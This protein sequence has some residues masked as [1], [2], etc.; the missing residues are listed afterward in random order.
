MNS[1]NSVMRAEQLQFI[2][3]I[4]FALI[5]LWHADIWLKYEDVRKKGAALAVNFFFILSGFLYSYISCKKAISPEVKDIKVFVTKKISKFYPLY[6]LTTLFAAIFSDL[7]W[8]L[9]N[10]NIEELV[11]SLCQLLQN[12]LLIQSWFPSDKGYFSYNSV[13][14]FL[15]TIMF[16]YIITIPVF[17]LLKKMNPKPNC[18]VICMA[19]LFVGILGYNYLMR[20]YNPEFWTYISPIG[21]AGVYC[22]GMLLGYMYADISKVSE[23]EEESGAV[24]TLI[25]ILTFIIWLGSIFTEPLYPWCSRIIWWIIPNMLLIYVF[26]NGKGLISELFRNKIFVTLGNITFEMYLIHQLVI[27]VY[28]KFPFGVKTGDCRDLISVFACMTITVVS[29]MIYKGIEKKVRDRISARKKLLR[30][31]L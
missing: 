12:L 2:R 9:K 10:L 7:V 27:K 26:V 17:I 5:F 19:I 14:W 28:S 20:E 30:S 22:L 3:F 15:S 16:L 13:G 1:K 24:W 21:E 25:E 8:Y 31:Y 29:A 6:I 23:E 11:R 4:S 18:I